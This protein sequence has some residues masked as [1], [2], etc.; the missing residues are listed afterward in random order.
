[1]KNTVKIYSPDQSYEM[2]KLAEKVNAEFSNTEVSFI[3]DTPKSDG[4]YDQRYAAVAN[5]TVVTGDTAHALFERIKNI[6]GER[7]ANGTRY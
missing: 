2:E 1:M 6:I 5:G 7:E 4:K 3:N